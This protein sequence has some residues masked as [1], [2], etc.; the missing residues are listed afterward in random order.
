MP[1]T[2]GAVLENVTP[3]HRETDVWPSGVSGET[4]HALGSLSLSPTSPLPVEVLWPQKPVD[5]T[6]EI[7]SDDPHSKPV[8]ILVRLTKPWYTDAVLVGKDASRSLCITLPRDVGV[9]KLATLTWQLPSDVPAKDLYNALSIIRR[10][11]PPN[12]ISLKRLSGSI[13]AILNPST[14][15]DTRGIEAYLSLVEA[16]ARVQEETNTS[17]P[18]PRRFTQDEANILNWADHLL[19]G[20]TVMGTWKQATTTLHTAG[21]GRSMLVNRINN[22][23]AA[24]LFA[25]PQGIEIA[26]HIIPLGMIGTH[27]LSAEIDEL[28]DVDQSDDAVRLTLVPGDT[29]E[30]ETWIITSE[31]PIEDVRPGVSRRFREQSM[32][33]M[34]QNDELLRRLARLWMCAT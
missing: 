20:E 32:E 7:S 30:Y 8:S 9:G 21:S 23:A 24:Y 5:L 22:G 18:A 16:L 2:P 26:D 14:N 17:F 6:L 11:Q 31:A 4:D 27:L 25:Q 10:L 33:F 29:N 28:H 3:L 12:R 34:K 1:G 19:Q 15:S 13:M